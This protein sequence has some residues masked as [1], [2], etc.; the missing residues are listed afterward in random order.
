MT[1][2]S[3]SV[4][5]ESKSARDNQ[6]AQVSHDRATEVLNKTKALFFALWQGVGLASSHHLAEF[7]ETDVETVQKLCQR[8]RDEFETDGL[9][10]LRGQ[11]LRDAVDILSIPSKTSQALVWTPRAALRLGMLLRDSEIAKAIRTSLLDAVEHIIPALAPTPEPPALPSPD[12]FTLLKEAVE[13][14]N[15]LGGFDDRQKMLLKDQLMNLLMQERLLPES[16]ALLTEVAEP[17]PA[18]RLEVPISDRCLDLGYNPNTK[19]L[20]R[21]GQV[22]AAFYRARHGRP[23]QK[24]E[25]F[26]GGTTRMVNVYTADD[27]SILD[28]AIHS[29]MGD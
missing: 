28:S 19:Q 20:L 8:H 9:K 26:V 23:P 22:A 24:R 14:G 1:I 18:K 4:L 17:E 16:S 11:D 12:R 29:V 3:D 6:L 15:Q 10:V 2:V 7:Y 27:L 5:V 21:I 25:Q 13:I